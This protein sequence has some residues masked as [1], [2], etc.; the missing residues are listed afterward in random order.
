MSDKNSKK[1]FAAWLTICIIWGTT[2]LAIRIG[3]RDLPPVLFAGFRWI[4][5]GP[6]LYFIL[7]LRNYKLPDKRDIFHSAIVGLL[8]LGGGNGFV[9]FA[10]QWLP[11]GLTALLIT[12]GPFWII[13]FESLIPS[14]P[15]LNRIIFLGLVCGLSGILLIFGDNFAGL[16][17]PTYIK[18][19]WGLMVAVLTWSLGTIYS[20]YKK[21]TV[22]PLMSAS[23]QMIV[24]GIFLTAF[25]LGLGEMSV[26]HFHLDSFLAFLYLLVIGSLI[27]YGCYIYAVAHLPISFVSTY[28]YI[29]PLIAL[30][31]GWLIL[32][33]SIT[34]PIILGAAVILAGVA[35]VKKGSTPIKLS[36]RGTD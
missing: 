30:F 2:Y 33:E 34:L 1:A 14:G 13:G 11:S 26:L 35:L 25:G 18:G 36:L 22:H 3:V 10:E 16:F 9:V 17:D 7:K 27:G 20:K 15:K 4:I 8:L 5:A 32:D 12:T 31:L 24:A 6:I 19:I 23:I 29:N 28:A 21:V